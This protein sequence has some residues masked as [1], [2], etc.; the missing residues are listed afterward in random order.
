M[1]LPNK[2]KKNKIN[3][4][5][6]LEKIN[7]KDEIID[8]KKD[9]M[10]IIENKRNLMACTPVLNNLTDYT[11]Y[12]TVSNLH[13]LDC[14]NNSIKFKINKNG[15]IIYLSWEPFSG[16]ITNIGNNKFIINQCLS[17]LPINNKRYYI[18]M[19]LNGK[20]HNGIIKIENNTKNGNIIF[21]L[22]KDR[23]NIAG[24]EMVNVYGSSIFWSIDE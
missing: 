23:S 20:R 6:N 21:K 7:T 12:A 1:S 14:K 16:K 10:Y 9:D 19:L 4:N 2:H 18:P 22:S 15:S 5:C 11:F 24:N 13:Y 3:N 8:I 17:D